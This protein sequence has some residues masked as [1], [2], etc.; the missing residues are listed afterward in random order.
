MAR[1]HK[2]ISGVPA[3]APLDEGLRRFCAEQSSGR[4]YKWSKA[5]KKETRKPLFRLFV[6]GNDLYF[7]NDS[8]EVLEYVKAGIGGFI[9]CGDDIGAISG[10]DGYLYEKVMPNEAVRIDTYDIMMDSD[11]VLQPSVEIGSGPLGKRE[12]LGR[13]SKGG[14][15]NEVLAWHEDESG[16]CCD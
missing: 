10:G 7:V 1:E 16:R 8:D 12:F 2:R 4:Q 6:D 9:T 5:Q 13:P 11:F 14:F 3:W 15:K